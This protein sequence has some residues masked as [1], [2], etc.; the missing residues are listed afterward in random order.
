[1]W[2][3]AD[4]KDALWNISTPEPAPTL[5]YQ[6]TLTCFG[7][8]LKDKSRHCIWIINHDR[9]ESY[10]EGS[11]ACRKEFR[12]SWV[13]RVVRRQW[14]KAKASNRDMATPICRLRNERRGPEKA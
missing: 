2:H 11:R 10:V 1:M 6:S 3:V 5:G 7:D 13:R 4:H 12:K 8:C 9:P 14:E